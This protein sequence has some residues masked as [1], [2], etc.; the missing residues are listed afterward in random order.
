MTKIEYKIFKT[1]SKLSSLLTSVVTNPAQKND[2]FQ[3]ISD[4]YYILT[5]FKSSLNDNDTKLNENEHG[6]DS[7]WFNRSTGQVTLQKS[8]YKN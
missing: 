2:S 4:S 5:E 1:K 3:A 8:N 7:I 6:M